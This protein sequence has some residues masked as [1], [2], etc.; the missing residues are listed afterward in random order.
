MCDLHEINRLLLKLNE[1]ED[2]KFGMSVEDR[3]T[4]SDRQLGLLKDLYA[5]IGQLISVW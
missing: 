5:K 1:L 3:I 2:S 4:L